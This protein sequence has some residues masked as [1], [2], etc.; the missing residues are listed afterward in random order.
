[1]KKSVYLTCIFILFISFLTASETRLKI[2][3]L[4]ELNAYANKRVGELNYYDINF[5][6]SINAY[7]DSTVIIFSALEMDLTVTLTPENN[8]LINAIRFNIRALFKQET[9]I[10]ELYLTMDNS[11]HHIYPILKGVPAIETNDSSRNKNITPFIDKVV[12]YTC[13]E[14]HFW[15]VA[16]EYEGCDGIEGL[17]ANKIMLYDFHC[18]FYRAFDART[19]QNHLLRD[20][21]YNPPNSYHQWAFLL[22]R[23]KP[24]LLDINRWSG[25]CKAALCITN[26]ADSECLSTL[27]AVFEGSNNPASPKYYNKGFFARNIPITN[28][29][30]GI[31]QPSLGEMWTK[32]QDY[33]NRIGYHTYSP[34]ADPP[35]TNAQALLNDL[36]SY[37]IRTWIDHAIPHNPE[38]IA[39]NG[40]YPDSLGYVADVI[41]QS[42]IEYIWSADTPPTN[43]FNA[44]DEPWRLP[45][46]VYEA[47][48]LTRPIWF[49]GRTREE[50]WEYTN[51]YN[52]VCMKYLITPDNLDALIVEN[53][54]HIAYTHLSIGSYSS[55]VGFY[56]ITPTGDYEIR[57]DVDEMLQM[58]DFYRRERG[59]W[60]APSE[61]IFD[62]M[63]AI[64]Q[65]KIT[66][67]EPLDDDFY[68]VTLHNYSDFDIPQLCIKYKERDYMI[69]LL[70]A[71]ESYLLYLA[72]YSP[73][74]PIPPAQFNVRYQNGNLTIK[75]ITGLN[76]DPLRLEIF[77]IRGQR[78]FS[79]HLINNGPEIN[80]PFAKYSSGIYLMRISPDNG[81]K[82]IVLRFSIVK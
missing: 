32:L 48:T 27:Q 51:Y 11:K 21:F 10:H 3:N 12:E 4:F 65:V 26:D 28:T 81:T 2:S 80:L 8:F 70:A 54:L 55:V 22:F 57:D 69:P 31:N 68:R 56:E 74:E 78:V 18:H 46:I 13:G 30:F 50:V 35:G 34:L 64:E 79:Q 59:L 71:G 14:Q 40:L 7:P 67:I 52:P 47:K 49:Y 61:D 42:Q 9:Y 36:V 62:R 1:M 37:N 17:M 24:V 16:S 39:Y 45:H 19:Q 33:G 77:N 73:D 53:G 60:I 25:N 82:P 20:A 44:Y 72:N 23:Q 75:N 58:L 6:K 5:T 76:I 63:L 41:N 43:P 66:S 29:I 38:D 15:I